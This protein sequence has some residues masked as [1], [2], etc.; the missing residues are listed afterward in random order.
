MD[1]RVYRLTARNKLAVALLTLVAL[2][3]GALVLAFGLALLAALAA[4][5]VVAGAG[6]A[7]WRRL[8][9]GRSSLPGAAPNARAGL[10]PG[11]EIFHPPERH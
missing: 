11:K 4:A 1:V 10:D 8:R 3:A 9:G 2:G 7:V 6:T 5:G